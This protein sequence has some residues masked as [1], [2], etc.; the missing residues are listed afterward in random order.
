MSNT[1]II[2]TSIGE[3]KYS[4]AASIT[5]CT[6]I[7]CRADPQVTAYNSLFVTAILKPFFISGI[8]NSPF[9]K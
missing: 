1:K 5:I 9:S 3:G 6:P 8:D 7:F 2:V 4:V